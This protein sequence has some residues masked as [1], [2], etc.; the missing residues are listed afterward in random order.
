MRFWRFAGGVLLVCAAAQA[1]AAPNESVV[2]LSGDD[3]GFVEAAYEGGRVGWFELNAQG[4]VITRGNVRFSA[5]GTN[6]MAIRSIVDPVRL[7][8]GD[9][10]GFSAELGGSNEVVRG[11]RGAKDILDLL[12]SPKNPGNIRL[13]FPDGATALVTPDSS[14]RL[15][16]MKDGSY[17]L[18]GRGRVEAM[19]REGQTFVLSANSPPMDGRAIGESG[20]AQTGEVTAKGAGKSGS[21]PAP[22]SPAT[23]V[24]LGDFDKGGLML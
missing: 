16:M 13:E 23:L 9:L 21:R 10:P 6:R 12:A 3:R 4:G 14:A 20:R 2:R 5:S 15:D 11:F 24:R 19:T 7:D 17:S 18:V 1:V 8:S 22:A